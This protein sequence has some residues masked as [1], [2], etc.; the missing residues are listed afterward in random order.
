MELHITEIE[1]RLYGLKINLDTLVQKDTK[2][3]DIPGL[4]GIVSSYV[5]GYDSYLSKTQQ[6]HYHIHWS[7][8]RA[9]A[10]MQKAKQRIMPDWGRTT[11][12]YPAKIKEGS[13]PYA[14]YGYACKEKTVYVSADLDTSQIEL[15]AHTQAAFKKSQI[16]YVEQKKDVLKA[17]ITFEEELFQY[18]DEGK[19]SCMPAVAELIVT[20]MFQKHNKLITRAP[21]DMYT[22]KWC[23]SRHKVSYAD[24]TRSLCHFSSFQFA[25]D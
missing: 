21:L 22:W 20:W 25:E 6:P 13:D 8:T 4:L 24:Y 3:E 19:P 16:N 5:I 7:D 23:I 10:A 15:H 17:K 12:L 18:L 2:I 11:K 1:T 14:W 9:L